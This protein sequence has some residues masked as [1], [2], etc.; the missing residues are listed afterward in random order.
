M[1][2]LLLFYVLKLVWTSQS[3]FYDIADF[4]FKEFRWS[5]E[6]LKNISTTSVCEW[7]SY[8]VYSDYHEFKKPYH[9][10]PCKYKFINK[11]VHFKNGILNYKERNI[12]YYCR[13]QCNYP[14]GDS[15]IIFG[16]WNEIKNAR[17]DCDVFEVNCFSNRSNK[18][19]FTDMF[20]QI[21]KMENK[22]PLEK[23]TF[24]NDNYPIEDIKNK[25]NVHVIV[26]DSISHYNLLRGL[27]NTKEYLEDEYS[28]VTF[29]YNNK[30][31]LNSRPNGL[32]FLINTRI[33][34]LHDLHNS[35][36]TKP[37]D[38]IL[39]GDD[40]CRE[41]IDNYPFIAK[42]YRQLNY[43]VYYGED[44]KGNVFAASGCV[45][46]NRQV[47]HHTLRPYTLRIHNNIY[48]SKKT[49]LKNHDL[50]CRRPVEYQLNH[51]AKFMKTY[52][53]SKQFSLTWVTRLS[54]YEMTGHFEY[55][56]YLKRY[57]KKNKDMF[58]KSFLIFMSDH[59]FR[60]EGFRNTEQGEFED[61]NPFL[62]ISPPK[63]LRKEKSEAL[64]NLRINANKHTSHFDIYATLLDIATEGSRRRFR[65]MSPFNLTTII[66]N[67]KIKGL[68]LLREIK[69]NR[70]CYDM[71]VTSEYCLCQQQFIKYDQSIINKIYGDMNITFKSSSI[72]M[73]IKR[74]FIN[75]LNEQLVIGNITEYCDLMKKNTDGIFDLK[76]TYNNNKKIIFKAR[77]EVLPKGIFDA[78]FDEFGKHTGSSI[79]RID[80]YAKFAETCLPTHPYRR[81]CYCKRKSRNHK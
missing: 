6:R 23:V 24:L 15:K 72:V 57:F 5:I 50:K 75:K 34:E 18:V 64:K 66:K 35:K 60:I 7:K 2:L 4:Q 26:L 70:T 20:I 62:I 76:Y 40:G 10:K 79:N 54:H 58:D 29:K 33:K 36:E 39:K 67:D 16:K 53:D 80:R 74:N 59:G 68:S 32:A 49:L 47:A 19:I 56:G 21:Y 27:K 11:F 61:N 22:P 9:H 8:P 43:T 38:F 17:P 13:Y 3:I 41:S 28:A 78:Y 63:K 44:S 42:Y 51:L 1:I 12:N 46:L 73:T 48:G 71:E 14:N 30:V 37:S 25:Y 45:G 77:I 31:G 52:E 55:D 69:V 81:F 65:G